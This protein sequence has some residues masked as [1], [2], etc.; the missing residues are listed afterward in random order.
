MID[1]RSIV[2]RYFAPVTLTVG[3]AVCV[4]GLVRMLADHTVSIRFDAGSVALVVL[5]AIASTVCA[6]R[7]WRAMLLGLSQHRIGTFEAVAQ[8]G[9][10]LVGKYAPGK[11]TGLAARVVANKDECPAHAAIVAT[12]LEQCGAVAA[13]ALVGT[14]AYAVKEYPA[15][16]G[17]A[18][19]A[20]VPIWWL[21]PGP[22][23][24]AIRHWHLITK[25]SDAFYFDASAIRQAFALQVLQ[26]LVLLLLV[27]IVASLVID[28]SNDQLLRI[29]GAY[30]VAVV[31][32]QLA[33]VFP[34]GIGPR[35]GAFVWLVSGAV[36]TSSAFA[37]A[38]ALRITTSAIDLG[39]GLAYVAR[40]LS[41]KT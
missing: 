35:E 41:A 1:A 23:R 25:R 12:V 17:G 22:I 3:V 2:R 28:G 32:G 38:L 33:F 5:S 34:G 16:V 10:T 21:S 30:G 36:G 7:A 11:V 9:L 39:A 8:L 19:L 15:A 40:R 37:I 13:A 20:A 31:A 24:W 6:A 4:V 27:C 26:W 18:V 14:A 29:A